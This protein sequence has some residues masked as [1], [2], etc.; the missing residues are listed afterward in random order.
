[1]NKIVVMTGK[2]RLSNQQI[3]Y[4]N[5][6]H[7]T[8][9]VQSIFQVERKMGKVSRHKRYVKIIKKHGFLKGTSMLASI[10]FFKMILSSKSKKREL[11]LGNLVDSN[12]VD[13]IPKIDGGVLNSEESVKILK[14][15]RPEL[16]F[17]CGAGIIKRQTFQTARLGMINLHHGIIPSIRGM[18]SVEWAIREN[19]PD[20][21]GIS[22]HT[23]NEGIDTGDLIGQARC[24]IEPDDDVANIYYKLDILGAKLLTDGLNFLFNNSTTIPAPKEVKSVYRSSFGVFDTLF[25]TLRK[26]SFFKK[27][28]IRP[29]EYAIGYYLNQ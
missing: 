22:L 4:I 15:I 14:E 26:R 7:K 20:W 24:S 23:I 9:G 1:M 8:F 10:P 27:V 18:L 11:L 19:R 12:N 17:Q 6:L 2:G 21:I 28:G 29:E 3:L 25:F 5:T 13:T 16:L